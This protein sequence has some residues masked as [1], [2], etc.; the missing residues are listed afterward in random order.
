MGYAFITMGYTL[1]K[2]KKLLEKRENSESE[3]EYSKKLATKLLNK[4]FFVD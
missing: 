3:K 2:D 1:I 4:M